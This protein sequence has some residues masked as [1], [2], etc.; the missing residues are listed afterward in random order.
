MEVGRRVPCIGNWGVVVGKYWVA[1]D[2]CCG[3]KILGDFSNPGYM[4]LRRGY[5]VG[6]GHSFAL[7]WHAQCLGKQIHTQ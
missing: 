6:V 4:C 7:H 2:C 3:K 5:F 1:W